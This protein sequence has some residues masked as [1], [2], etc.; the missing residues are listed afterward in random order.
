MLNCIAIDDEP[1][2]LKLIET[3]CNKIEF[4]NLK[5]TF[6]SAT[7]GLNYLQNESIDIAILDINMP[8]INGI[9]LSALIPAKIQ[10]VFITAYEKFAVKSYEVN[11][12]DYLVKPVSFDR[13]Y[14][15][16]QKCLNK[17]GLL[18]QQQDLNFD[19]S[20]YLLVKDSKVIHQVN[21]NN[22]LFIKGLKDYAK[23]VLINDEKIVTRESL[24]NIMEALKNYKF[25]RVH[26][27]FIIS[28]T[29]INSIEGLTIKI[30]NHKIPLNK[31]SK[32]YLLEEFK[33]GGILG[34]RTQ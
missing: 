20:K 23:I 21:V 32:K 8:E 2:A 15:A 1:L 29:Q 14:N 10:I 7:N 27:S 13:F 24:K 12:T 6:L 9:Q 11:T 22:I 16:M 34:H 3:H 28:L 26:K 5:E 18:L 31:I 17:K 25:I 33:K 30:K 4:I 19:E